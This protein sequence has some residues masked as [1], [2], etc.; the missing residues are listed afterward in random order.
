[1]LADQDPG[2]PVPR[3]DAAREG[4]V[5]A[6][7]DLDA[8][9]RVALDRAPVE[10][11][12]SV[13]APPPAAERVGPAR[14]TAPRTIG[15]DGHWWMRWRCPVNARMPQPMDAAGCAGAMRWREAPRWRAW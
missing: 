1:V 4:R 14:R 13:L 6:R 15:A 8:G 5:G 9:L 11:A 3:D 12:T 2:H 10:G 7:L